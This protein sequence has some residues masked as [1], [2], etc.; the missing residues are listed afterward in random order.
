[1]NAN[2]VRRSKLASCVFSVWLVM[3]GAVHAEVGVATRPQS[4]DNGIA[5]VIDGA[6]EDPTPIGPA[7]WRQISLDPYRVTLN[8]V[9]E[10][11][12]DGPPSVLSRAETGLI[13]VAWSRAS[14]SGFDIVISRFI[15]GAWTT[16]SV[17]V[18][19]AANDL[20]PQLVLDPDGSVHMFYWV[21]GTTP[22][23]MHTV[24][25]PD[26]SSWSTPALVSQPGQAACRPSGAFFD[27]ILRVAFEVHDFGFGNSP[28][29]VVVAHLD[30]G[31]FVPE[32]VAMTDNL[33]NVTPQVHSHAGHLWVDWVDAETSGGSGEIAWTR[34]NS[35]GQWE[36][37][38]YEP[39][40]SCEERNYLTRG[41]ARLKAIQ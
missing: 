40:A 16:P 37:I 10:A 35:Q 14:A 26:L 20:D 15:D 19:S 11:N 17:V 9:G 5:Y 25:P 21:D 1:M 31:S 24:A 33:G 8:T 22:Q 38:H 18:A 34:L 27:G 7:A 29:E 13:A 41:A 3:S 28:R 12:G 4:L 6:T 32:V 36:S 23:V 2:R 39:F 30:G